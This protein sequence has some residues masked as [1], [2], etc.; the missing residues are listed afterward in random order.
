MAAEPQG[1]ELPL[2]A[3]ETRMTQTMILGM[4]DEVG[5]DMADVI[6]MVILAV[7]KIGTM[8][9]LTDG[10]IMRETIAVTVTIPAEMSLPNIATLIGRNLAVG[11]AET[12]K[13]KTLT[14]PPIAT[15]GGEEMKTHGTNAADGEVRTK[16]METVEGRPT[17]SDADVVVEGIHLLIV[18][19][20]LTMKTKLQVATALMTNV[21]NGDED[22]T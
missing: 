4:G 9:K 18:R 14:T 21:V 11:E 8:V 19:I 13:E 3:M 16:M 22:R 17:V 5:V 2:A 12:L 6:R 1:R 20:H 15:I 7:E 10:I